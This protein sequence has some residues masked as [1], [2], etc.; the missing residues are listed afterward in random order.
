MSSSCLFSH[1]I[2]FNYLSFRRKRCQYFMSREDALQ[3]L[4]SEKSFP[5]A[6]LFH[7]NF[8][9]SLCLVIFLSKTRD[10]FLHSVITVVL[11]LQTISDHRQTISSSFLH[12]KEP[13]MEGIKPTK[14]D[15]GKDRHGRQKASS[16]EKTDDFSLVLCRWPGSGLS[17][18]LG[19]S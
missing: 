14:R 18:T 10:F 8:L 11:V 12:D 5:P 4:S 1:H 6:E 7:T 15:R 16:R 13:F 3:R 9:M 19:P 17:L 2:L